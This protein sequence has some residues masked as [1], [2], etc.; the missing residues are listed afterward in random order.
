VV[1]GIAHDQLD[2]STPCADFTV[3]GVLEH[4]VTGATAFTAAFGGTTAD[5]PDTA[6]VPDTTDA[7]SAIQPALMSLATA[8]GQPYDPPDAV[9]T[10]ARSF[11]ESV[12]EPLRGAVFG[13]P[14]DPPDGATP[15]ERLAAF[16]GRTV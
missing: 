13:D 15:I 11:A 10:E 9:V 2:N 14:T 7:L 5:P 4:M 3:H 16:T 1:T 8:T 12:L 6:D